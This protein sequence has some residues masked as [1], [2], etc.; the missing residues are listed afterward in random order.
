MH[1]ARQQQF[2]ENS[3][4]I[5]SHLQS[6]LSGTHHVLLLQLLLHQ[7]LCL[8]AMSSSSA[9]PAGPLMVDKKFFS[10]A[11]ADKNCLS[12]KFTSDVEYNS[13][14]RGTVQARMSSGIPRSMPDILVDKTLVNYVPLGNSGTRPLVKLPETNLVDI[15]PPP[16][17]NYNETYQWQLAML[18]E[19]KAACVEPLPS[20]EPGSVHFEISKHLGYATRHSSEVKTNSGN[21]ISVDWLLNNNR[22]KLHTPEALFQAVFFNEKGRYQFARPQ[23]ESTQ[24]RRATGQSRASGQN[25]FHAKNYVRAVQGHSVSSSPTAAM[26]KITENNLPNNAVHGTH[27]SA[28]QQIVMQGMIPGG[29]TD[30]SDRQANHF[31]T[32]LPN[33]LSHVV[34]G[35]KSGSSVCIFF[36]LAAW[37]ED[38]YEAYLSPNDVICV[39]RPI[40]PKYILAAIRVSDGY[41]YITQTSA[42]QIFLNKL[43]H[44]S[45][46]PTVPRM[47]TGSSSSS[48]GIDPRMRTGATLALEGMVTPAIED[49]SQNQAIADIINEA[50]NEDKQSNIEPKTKVS[51]VASEPN[52]ALGQEQTCD[53]MFNEKAKTALAAVMGKELQDL[54]TS[55]GDAEDVQKQLQ[56][57][58]IKQKVLSQPSNKSRDNSLRQAHHHQRK[59]EQLQIHRVG[60]QG[61]VKTACQEI[62]TWIQEL[63]WV[64]MFYRLI[65]LQKQ[66]WCR[67]P[68]KKDVTSLG[69]ARHKKL[70][71]RG[72]SKQH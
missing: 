17:M 30:S 21:W 27:I 49:V 58:L 57:K 66:T 20:W 19:G 54:A 3:V 15:S 56:E 59:Q 43:E 14:F 22:R 18:L 45:L 1:L 5:R 34:S 51:S 48:S 52:T 65:C 32:T 67:K 68:L 26:T 4:C 31:A 6:D 23:Y 29:S 9:I 16:G 39:F 71:K 25:L 46:G 38:G 61:F 53:P 11:H 41:D 36:D 50:T 60:L 62:Q 55:D 69:F 63:P 28:A 35:Y 70:N 47:R 10:S 2:Q 8:V 12:L 37:I 42:A 44:K 13:D 33:D 24:G 7:P 72:R 40:Q 64:S